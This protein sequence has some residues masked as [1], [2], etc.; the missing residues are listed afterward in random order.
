MRS[1]RPFHSVFLDVEAAADEDEDELDE[2][3]LE[4]EDVGP[5]PDPDLTP[6][7]APDCMD[8]DEPD[9]TNKS[10]PNSDKSAD[11]RSK[12]IATTLEI[13]EAFDAVNTLRYSQPTHLAGASTSHTR[14]WGSCTGTPHIYFMYP[15]STMIMPCLSP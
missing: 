5:D 12:Y 6:D 3:E 1:K 10:S 9:E 7:D 14:R 4:E 13:Q 11:K 15:R 2:D 8:V